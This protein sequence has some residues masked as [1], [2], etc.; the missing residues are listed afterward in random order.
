MAQTE[1][2]RVDG[3]EP[4]A[5]VIA[6]AKGA[7]D[8]GQ[9]HL[10]DVFVQAGQDHGQQHADQTGQD[11]CAK[12][13]GGERRR[14]RLGREGS[15]RGGHACLA[16]GVGNEDMGIAYLQ[17]TA[18]SLGRLAFR[19]NRSRRSPGLRAVQVW[20]DSRHAPGGSCVACNPGLRVA[21][22]I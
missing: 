18:P 13:G 6:D 15:G 4:G 10:G 9:R 11:A 5:L 16:P 3:D 7:A 17:K 21:G 19:K 22:F 2:S 20:A 12:C 14:R 8:V 1:A